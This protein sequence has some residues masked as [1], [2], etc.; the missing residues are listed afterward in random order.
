MKA[1]AAICAAALGL[2]SRAE[3]DMAEV[4][5]RGQLRVVVAEGTPQLFA[6][7]SGARPGLEREVL[8]GFCR[9]HRVDLAIVPVSSPSAVLPALLKREGDLAAGGLSALADMEQ[10]IELSAE[11]LPTRHVVVTRKPTRTVLTLDELRAVPKVGT[12]KGTALADAV[13]AAGVPDTQV[14]D[15]FAP[16]G[17]LAAL[18][19]G[20][21][22][23]CIVGLEEALPAQRHDP[24]LLVGMHVGGKVS[25][26]FGT[27]K[28]DTQLRGA[29]NE[30]IRNLRRSPAWNR[31]VLS[32]FG[33]AAAD[34][35]KAAR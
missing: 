14:D 8:N 21:V 25:L 18:K 13:S 17:L 12:A 23:A 3:A 32:Y 6:W 29:L 31:L 27:R 11:V 16:D 4:L 30:Y 9:L 1:I 10:G 5:K 35:L 7:K 20:K 26:A 15:S 28:E 34:M 24:D 2:V 19:A 33:D 22:A